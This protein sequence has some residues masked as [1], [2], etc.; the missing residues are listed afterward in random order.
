M[1]N[2][3]TT[4]AQSQ[5]I[6]NA[7]IAKVSAKGYAVAANLGALASKSEVAETDLAEA[8]ASKINGKADSATTLS[9]YG[10]TD[11]YTKTE[12][13]NAIGEAQA[14]V[15]KP[16][17]SL[18]AAEVVS[19][20]LVA[21][22]LGKVYN[23]SEN[24]TTTSDFVDG[25]GHVITAGTNIYIV[26]TDTTGSSPVYKFDVLAGE[27]GVATQSANGL[28]SSTDKAKLDNADVTAY[29]GTGAISVNNHE[30][31][32]A[33]AAASTAGVGGNAGTMSA[34]DKEKLDNA[35]VT[36]YTGSGAISVSNH[37]IS[38]A[39]AVAS[40]SG[41][42]GNAGT[43][44]AADKEKLDNFVIASAQDVQDV[45]DALDNL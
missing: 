11:A 6:A 44:S 38:V 34:A 25:A 27:Y 4:L 12:V 45:I 22:N 37:Q 24:I 31:S 32:V 16:G 41:T 42:G 7:V 28:M 15:L 2:I 19:G 35:D 13:D 33:A 43:M 40:T 8:L 29:T 10:I 30:I 26:D 18:A 14:S 17:G 5:Q 9:G 21:G 39:A 1:S 20:L 3:L 23:L 36:A